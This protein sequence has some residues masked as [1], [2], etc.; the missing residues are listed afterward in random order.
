M[1]MRRRGDEEGVRWR[2]EIRWGVRNT[3]GGKDWAADVQEDEMKKAPW[4]ILE[5]AFE[6]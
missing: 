3:V 5:E 1:I 4:K 2:E 6:F